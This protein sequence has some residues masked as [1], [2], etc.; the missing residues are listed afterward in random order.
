LKKFIEDASFNLKDYRIDAVKLSNIIDDY[1]CSC[2]EFAIE[3]EALKRFEHTAD[4]VY[5]VKPY[6][7]LFSNG[8]PD[9]FVININKRKIT[10]QFDK[11]NKI[12]EILEAFKIFD[13]IYK[14][15]Q[16][17]A[18]I[19]LKEEITPYLIEMLEK[20]LSSATNLSEFE[21]MKNYHAHIYALML[22]GHFKEH[23]AHQVII[24]ILKMPE[25]ILEDLFGG[26]LF[27][28]FPTILLRTC[29]DNFELVKSLSLNQEACVNSRDIALK[30]MV[31][32]VAEKKFERKK[33]ISILDQ[34]FMDN[35]ASY[36][37]DFADRL[38]RHSY[39]IFPEELMDTINKAYEDGL[40]APGFIGPQD[41]EAVLK[42]GKT[43]R[44]EAI[45]AELHKNSLDDIHNR[46]S[47]W[48][49]FNQKKP[50]ISPSPSSSKKSNKNKTKSKKKKRKQAKT[51]KKKNR[52]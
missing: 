30:A 25:N 40:I 47:W 14:R 44:L 15:K 42:A 9:L 51:S 2:G 24:D 39:N 43:T 23:R 27:D 35:P 26:L 5:S 48:A 17:D 10:S 19:E 22:L 20:I 50:R 38:A 41:F 37:W 36:G 31:F 28:D 46:M 7:D 3:Q 12:S 11:N 45:K 29:N 6:D 52:R 16:I 18:A 8:E 32:G 34:L 49:C 1:G 33:L 21:D 13:G 4:L